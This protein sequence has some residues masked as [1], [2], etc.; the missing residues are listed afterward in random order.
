LSD[1][2]PDLRTD[3]DVDALMSRLAARIEPRR[4]P[5]LPALQAPAPDDALGGVLAASDALAV[6]TV[7]AIGLVLETLDDMTE[8]EAPP[9]AA[10]KRA[11][12][13]PRRP[14]ARAATRQRQ[15]KKTRR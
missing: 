5:S 13:R 14:T 11:V 8:L 15:R 12:A 9:P 1:E 4:A 10:Q 2:L 6:A 7:R 3:E